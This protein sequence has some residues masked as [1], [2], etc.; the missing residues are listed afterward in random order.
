MALRY[1]ARFRRCSVG[2][3]GLGCSSGGAI[4]LRLQPR[5]RRYRSA[6]CPAA[7]VRRGGI[8]PVRSLRTTFSHASA[9]SPTCDR[10]IASSAR[11][12]VF[13][14]WLWQ[15]T[16][17]LSSTARGGCSAPTAARRRCRRRTGTRGAA[18]TIHTAGDQSRLRIR[19][20]TLHRRSFSGIAAAHGAR[21]LH[22]LRA[23]LT[24]QHRRLRL[25]GKRIAVLHAVG[26]DQR[27]PA[28]LGDHVE[29]RALVEQILHDA[30]GAAIGRRVHRRFADVADDV[31]VGAQ[32]FDQQLDG[33]E[34]LLLASRGPG[35]RP[36]RCPPPPSAA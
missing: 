31:D 3:P 27:R 36:T 4:E 13:T 23:Q 20:Q 9:C 19:L 7:D 6:P 1:S 15:V 8:A 32:F 2:R 12:A 29:L 18:T 35:S 22:F 10:S 17:Y 14:R 16:Q 11:P 21:T 24:Q 33:F 34:H 26:D 28:V 30:V 5:R 25:G